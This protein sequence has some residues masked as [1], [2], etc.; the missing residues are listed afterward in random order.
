MKIKGLVIKFQKK[1]I[2]NK[3]QLYYAKRLRSAA[4][5]LYC[6]RE[7]ETIHAAPAKIQEETWQERLKE[8][9]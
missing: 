5:S 3:Q 1:A 4:A 2:K 7:I 8:V 6:P 9:V